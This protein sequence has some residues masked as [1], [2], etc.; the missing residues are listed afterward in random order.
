MIPSKVEF[1]KPA[2]LAQAL[3]MLQEKGDSKVLA[4]GHS[5]I[6]LMKLRL[7]EPSSV[8]SISNLTELQG[9]VEED[10]HFKIGSATTHAELGNHS[11]LH[12]ILPVI[13]QTALS[14]GDIQVRNF[15]TIGGSIAHADPAADWPG[16]LLATD[17]VIE[18]AN[19]DGSREVAAVDFFQG[20][21]TTVLAEHEIITAIKIPIPPAGTRSAYL[22][23]PQPSSRFAIVGCAVVLTGTDPVEKASVAFNGVS[24]AAF[25]DPGVE[26]ALAGKT[27]NAQTI[28]IVSQLAAQGIE[29]LTDYHASAEYRSHLAKLYTKRTL[30]SLI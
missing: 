1:Q 4:G 9:I 26:S 28:E 21:F 10:D 24:E 5:L 3:E 19:L 11:N 8:V 6:P 13:C 29:V 12:N 17:A 27:L 14:I 22:K 18:I 16:A 15:G 2:S 7:N 30:M 20:F 23:F 25:R